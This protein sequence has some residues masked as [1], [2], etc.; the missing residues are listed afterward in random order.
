MTR[1]FRITSAYVLQYTT[2]QRRRVKEG[3]RKG[4]QRRESHWHTIYTWQLTGHTWQL[5][6][7]TWQLTGHIRSE[8]AQ[9]RD[10]GVAQ[11]H[12]SGIERGTW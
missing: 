4:M 11:K 8:E 6:G 2:H 12:G 10:T 5:T 1:H 7:H 9:T 3:E